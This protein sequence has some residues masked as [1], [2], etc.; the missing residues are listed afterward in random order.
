MPFPWISKSKIITWEYCPF[1]FYNQYVAKQPK[2]PTD[3]MIE[4]T[5]MHMVFN[6]FYEN[7]HFHDA[8]TEEFTD[9]RVKIT[10]HPFRQFIY[11]SC[12]EFIPPEHRDYRKYKYILS[13]FATIETKRFL[14][15]N[16]LLDKK[17]AWEKFKPIAVEKRLEYEP[18]HIFGT[19]DRVDYII[20]E[21]GELRIGIIDYKTGNVPKQVRD[22]DQATILD[23]TLP[24]SR[25]KEIHF[26]GLLWLLKHGWQISDDL[27]SF[28]NDDKWH[29]WEKEGMTRKQVRKE[30]KAHLTSLQEDYKLFKEGRGLLEVGDVILGYYF[31]NGKKQ[32]PK[33]DATKPVAFRPLKKLNYKS[34]K[35]VYLSINEYRSMWKAGDFQRKPLPYDVCKWKHCS[36]FMDCHGKEYYRRKK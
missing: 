14:R 11:N 24:S 35:S 30:K 1:S 20:L 6:K 3:K 28:L 4:G 13:N 27:K 7:L 15:L 18:I 12:M 31:L 23:W 32:H 21:S 5:N 10:R 34:M 26:Y 29:Y 19:I 25:M 16:R 2:K 9:P 33:G 22:S 17:E 36:Q 8:Y